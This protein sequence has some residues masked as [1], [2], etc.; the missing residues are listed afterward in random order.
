[1]AMTEKTEKSNMPSDI[2]KNELFRF[3]KGV[4]I[5]EDGEKIVLEDIKYDWTK[6]WLLLSDGPVLYTWKKLSL[7]TDKVTRAM[8]SIERL[9]P[10]GRKLEQ[11]AACG[12]AILSHMLDY[13]LN[14]IDMYIL[15][16]KQLESAVNIYK[17]FVKDGTW[18]KRT[19]FAISMIGVDEAPV[20]IVLM[21]SNGLQE[22]LSSFDLDCCAIGYYHGK[23]WA[24]KR[25]LISLA[26]G[27]IPIRMEFA[28]A[29]I[30]YRLTKY[31]NRGFDIAV[32]KSAIKSWDEIDMK[33]VSAGQGLGMVLLGAGS[34]LSDI[35]NYEYGSGADQTYQITRYLVSA[36]KK[37]GLNLPIREILGRNV[38]D[39]WYGIQVAL[40]GDL[41][42]ANNIGGTQDP[43]NVEQ[44]NA[45]S[46]HIE[47]GLEDAPLIAP[48]TLGA[49]DMKA[50]GAKRMSE[51]QKKNWY[52][53]KGGLPPIEK[54]ART[55]MFDKKLTIRLK[56]NWVCTL[57]D[58][59]LATTSSAPSEVGKILSILHTESH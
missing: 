32:P 36:A 12:G 9:I 22:T 28:T 8:S 13:Q 17:H 25:A 15:G 26:T 7:S 34:A 27:V 35:S 43:V 41:H 18:T 30:D 50:L 46:K 3:E 14:D 57:P 48:F 29:S 51:F 42:I 20:Q 59:T 56:K 33:Y 1:M 45:I 6:D 52:C 39:V 55:A 11:F 5:G 49:E 19:D 23:L 2:K 21:K 24:L 38:T 53:K 16:D 37:I 10:D 58:E 44:Y 47:K 40:P 54:R 4:W 31:R